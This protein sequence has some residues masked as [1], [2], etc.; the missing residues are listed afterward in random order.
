M[1]P[2][3]YFQGLRFPQ[4]RNWERNLCLGVLY[5]ARASQEV[6]T[7]LEPAAWEISELPTLLS[8]TQSRLSIRKSAVDS[9]SQEIPVFLFIVSK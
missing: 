6:K 2:L 7:C 5:R 4:H 8:L 3:H 1:N 9:V